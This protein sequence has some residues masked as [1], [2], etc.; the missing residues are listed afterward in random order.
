MRTLPK[1]S[2]A[3]PFHD[4]RDLLLKL[5]P[6]GDDGFEGLLAGALSELSGLTIR[7]AKSGLQFGRDG[8]SSFGPFAI[9]ME[10]KRYRDKLG[11]EDLAGKAVLAAYFLQE[12][13]DVWVVGATSEV[14]DV[15]L[16]K[17][18]LILEDYGVA[19]LPLDW[20]SHP[21][22]PLAV[23]LA[24]TKAG[25]LAWFKNHSNGLNQSNLAAQL[26]SISSDPHYD[27]QVRHLRESIS[28]A[29]VGLDALRRHGDEW[30][31]A[32][33]SDRLM[34]QQAFGQYVT[35]ADPT[36][37]AT[38]RP[39]L[40]EELGKL[41]LPDATD[42]AIVAVLGSE[43]VG[44]TWLVAKWWADLPERPIMLMI[45]GRRVGHLDPEEPLESLARILSH[46]TGF[47]GESSTRSWLRRLKRW[48]GQG[49]AS[50]LRFIIM[51]DGLNDQPT[52]PWADLIKGLA[53]EAQALGG[54]V[55]VTCRASFWDREVFPK[56]PGSVAVR[57]LL[58]EDFSEEELATVLARKGIDPVD[59]PA[60]VLDFIRNPRVCAVAMDLLQRLSLQPN[61][62]TIDRLLFEYWRAR[63]EERG[64]LVGH[65]IGDFDKLI[66]SHARAWLDQPNRSFDLDQWS[67]HSGVPQRISQSHVLNDLTDIVEG[68]FLRTTQDDSGAYE[69]RNEVLPYALALLVNAE[70][71]DGLKK[72]GDPSEH[73]DRILDSVRGFDAIAEIL[74]ASVRLACL[75]DT[76]D[77]I[78][79]A[80]LVSAWLGLQNIDYEASAAMAAYVR[81]RPDAFL[82]AAES[83]E[84]RS[85]NFFHHDILSA[86]LQSSRDFPAVQT[87]MVKRLPKWLGRW[88]RQRLTVV[89]GHDAA[90]RQADREARLDERLGSLSASENSLFRRLTSEQSS[91]STMAL[92][93]V[94]ALLVAGRPLAPY[95]S[96]LFGWSLARLIAGDS[97][98]SYESLAWVIRFN[99]IDSVEA[100]GAV[101][102]LVKDVDNSSSKWI[103][104]AAATLL[105]FS[106][107]TVSC[108][109]A[110]QLDPPGIPTR[111]R[112]I[113]TF[114][115]TNPH[116][117]TAKEGSNLDNARG[118]ALS[119]VP[120]TMWSSRSQT[121]ESHRLE[122]ITPALA[123][124]DPEVIASL[125]R[126][127]AATAPDRDGIELQQLAWKLPQISPL[128]DKMTLAAMDAAY[129]RVRGGSIREIPDLKWAVLWM[130]RALTPHFFAEAQLNLVLA[131][132]LECP[133]SLNLRE[134]FHPL[135]GEILERRLE[136]AL[137]APS[138]QDLARIL[139]FASGSTPELT[140]R[141]RSI[142]AE[143]LNHAEDS[144]SIAAAEI[145]IMA[146]D[147]ELNELMLAHDS[148]SITPD[149]A[150]RRQVLGHAEAA[151]IVMGHRDDLVSRLQPRFLGWVAEQMGGSALDLLALYIDRVIGRLMKPVATVV[152]RDLTLCL[153]ISE[154]G[155]T[156][157]KWVKDSSEDRVPSDVQEFFSNMN[158][159]EQ[160]AQRYSEHQRVIT[161]EMAAYEHAVS[162]EGVAEVAAAPQRFGLK[163][164]V[165]ADPARV[166]SWIGDVLAVQDVE[167]RRR[168]RNLGLSLAEAY[169]THDA[170]VAAEVF[171][172]LRD[173]L[174]VAN[175]L[176]GAEETP[177]Y[178]DV[179]FS[180]SDAGP[181]DSLR[182][183][184][185]SAALDDSAL[186]IA[187]VA[188]EVSGATAWLTR[189]V[190][191]LLASNQPVAQARGLTI[192]GLRQENPESDRLLA[193]DRGGGFLGQALA[194]ARKSYQQAIW[195]R[196]WL[197]SV[198]S[199]TNPMDFWS[200][201]IL[202]EAVSDKRFVSV[203]PELTASPLLQLF[204]SDLFTRMKASA[205]KRSK[206]RQ[207][208][209]FGLKAPQDEVA[210]AIFGTPAP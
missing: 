49:A 128:F 124:F 179:L 170:A 132:P 142:I 138:S 45:A 188:A 62:V 37:P 44:K 101:R 197:D 23:L 34:S 12:K 107:D 105:R 140:P 169:S 32:R 106:G 11:L 205:E 112:Q 187:T 24:A 6:S 208:T 22:P 122:S 184:A 94:A 123:R 120:S 72:G 153:R 117:P 31:R 149:S 9:A 144:V 7:L 41:A 3:T 33:L 58:V 51:I 196:H 30:L 108:R 165:A 143:S 78:G 57:S 92:D 8:K 42:L 168:I 163:Q 50:Q 162:E 93:N 113:E 175:I 125:L 19:L 158:D 60:K 84:D 116:D 87:A 178:E 166:R 127:I 43:G 110:D 98:H 141:S 67:R 189:Y 21:L 90:R 99:P 167:V 61:E 20:A 104:G 66:R 147:S 80:S 52:R 174:P 150:Y 119:M 139:F 198:V 103:K 206:K 79:R 75:N 192:A 102:E 68:R 38:P 177:L 25:T 114:C 171:R 195:T 89:P 48:K 73:L 13:V 65:N 17:L 181:I 4:L 161:Q 71:K 91:S 190:D 2:T 135:P 109:L 28:A 172:H 154:D 204:G 16:E 47:A 70:F 74:S 136:A 194:A 152:P 203:F 115:D 83:P 59:L 201:G 130:V 185:F 18:T 14:G 95:A 186:E 69:F 46:Q 176:I 15:T 199:A 164:L 159:P 88:S 54:L 27:S 63:M 137:L 146:Q 53:R 202:A 100:A 10:A 56:L 81:I 26:D 96:G 207:S 180:C 131:L 40:V 85:R 210:R 200:F 160:A 209:L 76:F 82:D 191:D 126:G 193:I 118:A 35:V 151:A 77:P 29:N 86:L 182:R 1:T 183:D 129:Q 64:D 173:T 148:V 36:S 121:H 55:V 111:W 97:P 157:Q 156:S 5:K 133:L 145:V 39:I 134:S 155:L